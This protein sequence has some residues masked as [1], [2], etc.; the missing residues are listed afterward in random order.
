MYENDSLKR[1]FTLIELLVV[2]A[3]IGTLSGVV[4]TS[5]NSARD[6][7]YL[8]TA[9]SEMKSMASALELYSIDNGSYPAD[10]SRDIPPGIEPYLAGYDTDE[11]P[12]AAWPGSVYDWENWN[13]PDNPGEKIYQISIRFCPVGGSISSCRFPNE[14]WA[15]DFGVNSAVYY[16]VEG[17]CRSHVSEDSDYPGYCVNC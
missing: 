14:P 9:R 12:A 17:A 5:L 16:C 6:R 10:V 1:G 2:I 4:V 8:S 15:E 3:I 11:W 7:A 13:D